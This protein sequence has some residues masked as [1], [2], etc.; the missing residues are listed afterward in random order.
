MIEKI[1]KLKGKN[2]SLTLKI[3]DSYTG[4]IKIIEFDTK[5]AELRII[6]EIEGTT[7]LIIPISQIKSINEIDSK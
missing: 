1:E 5:I 6:F 3:G 7:G 2:C 4:I